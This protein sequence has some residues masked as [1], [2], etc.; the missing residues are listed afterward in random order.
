[1]NEKVGLFFGKFS[2]LFAHNTRMDVS[3]VSGKGKREI[4]LKL[5]SD[6]Y[7]AIVSVRV[8]ERCEQ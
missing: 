2:L 4:V 6:A 5:I 7:D 3:E 1:M 8:N